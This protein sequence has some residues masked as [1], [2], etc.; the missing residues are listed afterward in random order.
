MDLKKLVPSLETCQKLQ[1]L[2]WKNETAFVIDLKPTVSLNIP[3]KYSRGYKAPTV[4]ELGEVLKQRVGKYSYSSNLITL[5]EFHSYCQGYYT[6]DSVLIEF[7][8]GN[9]AECRAQL[10]I[11]LVENK[12]IEL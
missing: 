10:I 1:D 4:S 9:E 12:H 3:S 11:W 5:V 2:G 7:D 6:K 8:N